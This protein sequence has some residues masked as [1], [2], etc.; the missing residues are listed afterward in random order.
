MPAAGIV[1]ALSLL[2][3]MVLIVPCVLMTLVSGRL[4]LAI[5]NVILHLAKGTAISF[6]LANQVVPDAPIPLSRYSPAWL[7]EAPGVV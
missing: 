4:P 6:L 3:W 7:D 2:I 5:R 1:E